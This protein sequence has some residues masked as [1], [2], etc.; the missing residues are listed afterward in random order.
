MRR[1]HLT[2]RR[3][4]MRSSTG[5]MSLVMMGRV[6]QDASGARFAVQMVEREKEVRGLL[7]EGADTG[8]WARW[9]RELEGN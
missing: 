1:N 6:K 5:L 7:G 9:T 2:R 3:W 4:I 8:E